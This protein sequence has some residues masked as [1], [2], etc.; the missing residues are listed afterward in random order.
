MTQPRITVITPCC[1]QEHH[2]ERTICSVLDQGYQNLDFRVVDFGSDDATRHILDHYAGQLTWTNVDRAAGVAAAINTALGACDGQVVSILGA[3]EVYLPGALHAVE[4]RWNTP[5]NTG[6]LVGHWA[7]IGEDDRLLGRTDAVAPESLA[8][9]LMHDCAGWPLSAIFWDVRLA[10]TMGDF[11]TSLQFSFDYEYWC[12]LL[13]AGNRPQ[14]VP[15]KVLA[16]RRV[17]ARPGDGSGILHRG[18][19]NIAAA[20]RYADQ[21]PWRQRYELWVNCDR[22]RRIYAL[23]AAELNG[24]QATRQ[25]VRQTL[26]RPWW[27]ADES[28]RRTLLRGVSHP[29]PQHMLRPAA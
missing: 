11:D 9:F 20:M 25:L 12:R 22:R 18:L 23:A 27:L 6:W 15:H 4:R 16:A 24:R 13:A 28:F 26:R 3:D 1:N 17:P 14:V 29:V 8:A 10:R 21:L 5:S 2:V 7:S 19:E